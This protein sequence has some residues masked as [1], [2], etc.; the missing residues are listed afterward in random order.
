MGTHLIGL[1]MYAMYLGMPVIANCPEEFL[2]NI[3]G[4]QLPL[5]HARNKDEIVQWLT[6]LE[7]EELRLEIGRKSHAFALKHFGCTKTVDKVLHLLENPYT[8]L[9]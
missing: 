1:G 6:I 8:Q 7:S 9:P 2:Y 4:E 5:C 3:W